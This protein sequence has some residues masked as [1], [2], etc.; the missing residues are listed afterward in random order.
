MS[1][2]R[3][4]RVV[5][6]CVPGTEVSYSHDDYDEAL[7]VYYDWA[8][9]ARIG[10]VTRMFDGGNEIGCA[11]RRGGWSRPFSVYWGRVRAP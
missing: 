5:H 7:R 9:A 3:R 2:D 8:E 6:E 4:Y 10:A 11:S 1:A